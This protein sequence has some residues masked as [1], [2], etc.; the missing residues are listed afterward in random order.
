M[1]DA[2]A[3]RA[4]D[5]KDV[6]D[7]MDKAS[8]GETQVAA[9]TFSEYR[10]SQAA[11]LSEHIFSVATS[12]SDACFSNWRGIPLRRLLLR[13]HW[14][15]RMLFLRRSGLW[16]RRLLQQAPAAPPKSPA[17]KAKSKGTSGKKL[18][19]PPAPE[20]KPVSAAP[21]A[22]H[23]GS[24]KGSGKGSGKGKVSVGKLQLGCPKCRGS[25]KGC[26]QCRNPLYKGK[27][28]Q[29]K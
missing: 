11:A 21:T 7:D 24:C 10:L 17:P 12:F 9:R 23:T 4:K 19:A 2:L 28:Y 3:K 29:A 8:S 5:K 16:E 26:L 20:K 18:P 1:L 14:L 15:R 6:K 13:R 25:A 22:K 27:R